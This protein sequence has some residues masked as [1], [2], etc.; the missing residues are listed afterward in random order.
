M[1]PAESCCPVHPK[2]QHGWDKSC[3]GSGSSCRTRSPPPQSMVLEIFVFA[4]CVQRRE[5]VSTES[6]NNQA[7]SLWLY[8]PFS[9]LFLTTVAHGNFIQDNWWIHSWS[10]YRLCIDSMSDLCNVVSHTYCHL[11]CMATMK[12]QSE[13]QEYEHHMPEG[14]IF[15]V[16]KKEW[17][18]AR[19]RE[20]LAAFLLLSN[21]KR[22]EM[23]PS[24]EDRAF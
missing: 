7:L 14:M 8:F 24:R 11:A 17:E 20:M 18:T 12:A 15:S 6:I 22:S 2:K 3:T 5:I 9:L 19:G 4:V 13:G 21:D 16:I 1:L 23:H 10:L